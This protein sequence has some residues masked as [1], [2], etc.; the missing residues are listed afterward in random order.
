MEKRWA[1]GGE[2]ATDSIKIVES[3][4]THPRD[5]QRKSN[6]ALQEGEFQITMTDRTELEQQKGTQ[7]EDLATVNEQTLKD[8]GTS[9][10][11]TCILAE[12]IRGEVMGSLE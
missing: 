8:G 4:T 11:N 1:C 9:E 5:S 3:G 10:N 12:S 2:I 6:P 7:W